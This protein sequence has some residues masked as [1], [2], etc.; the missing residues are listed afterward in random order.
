[1]GIASAG[2]QNC[3][4]QNCK[5]KLRPECD[6]ACTCT[7]SAWVPSPALAHRIAA[8][9]IARRSFGL[10]AI[11]HVQPARG[12]R[13]TLA[14]KGCPHVLR[15][16]ESTLGCSSFL[17]SPWGPWPLAKGLVFLTHV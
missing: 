6:S 15:F 4:T 1:M 16:L 10:S 11:P 9:R 3:G 13:T 7:I 14:S 5:E 12:S 17:P 2:P 8:H